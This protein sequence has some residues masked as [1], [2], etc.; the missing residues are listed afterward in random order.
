MPNKQVGVRGC[1]QR[2]FVDVLKGAEPHPIAGG[3]ANVRDVIVVPECHAGL[4]AEVADGRATLVNVD[5]IESMKVTCPKS[6]YYRTQ[7]R[8]LIDSEKL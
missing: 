3:F 2:W 4:V 5:S 8:K 1:G 6:A 7:H